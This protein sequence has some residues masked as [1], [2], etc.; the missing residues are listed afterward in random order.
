M[1]ALQ[2]EISEEDNAE[3]IGEQVDIL[4]EGRSKAALKQLNRTDTTDSRSPFP[5]AELTQNQTAVTIE[6]Q[7]QLQP[8]KTSLDGPATDSTDT[9]TFPASTPI[10]LV[11]RTDCDRIAV[12]EGNPRLIGVVACVTIHDCTPTT[13]LGSIVTLEHQ[14]RQ[15]ELLPIL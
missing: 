6:S 8:P 11:G 14:H 2:N 9:R 13:L 15:S 7:Q 10:Q 1:L 12:F 3:F 5:K 4:V